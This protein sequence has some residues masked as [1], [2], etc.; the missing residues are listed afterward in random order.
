M[1]VTGRAWVFGD[2]EWTDLMI[3]S[4]YVS[5]GHKPETLA[6][7]LWAT[8]HPNFASEAKPGDIIVAGRNFGCG[9]IRLHAILAMKAAGFAVVIAESF[10]RGFYRNAINQA[11]PILEC[12]GI[13]KDVIAG[14]MLEV[15]LGDARVRNL[16]TMQV[17]EGKKHPD[18]VQRIYDQGGIIPYTIFRL[19]ESQ[20]TGSIAS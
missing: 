6:K 15:D 18:F 20:N 3:H 4:R 5:A 19:K 2:N 17:L 7:Y 13:T 8:V 1:T 10:A 16:R 14:D 11:V 9:A 12:P